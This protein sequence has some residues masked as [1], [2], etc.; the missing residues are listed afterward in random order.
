MTGPGPLG[1]GRKSSPVG[2][3]GTQAVLRSGAKL[4]TGAPPPVPSAARADSRTAAPPG[5][6][7]KAPPNN[8]ICNILFDLFDARLNIGAPVRLVHPAATQT[9][10]WTSSGS[11]AGLKLKQLPFDP[12][13]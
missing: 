1:G 3:S 2:R 4:G 5:S 11:G 9:S 10:G 8:A 13:P 12:V 6:T 7:A